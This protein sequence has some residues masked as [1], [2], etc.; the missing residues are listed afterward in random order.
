MQLQM[1]AAEVTTATH[2]RF[3]GAAA[4]AHILAQRTCLSA[5]HAACSIELQLKVPASDQAGQE[6]SRQPLRH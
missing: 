3:N 2:S 6:R 5:R 1:V 4:R